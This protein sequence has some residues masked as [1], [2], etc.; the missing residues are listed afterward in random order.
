MSVLKQKLDKVTLPS[1]RHQRNFKLISLN[2]HS[3]PTK[4]VLP[5]AIEPDR[6]SLLS[7]TS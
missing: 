1:S 3:S 2:R 6:L 7:S 5:S 4:I